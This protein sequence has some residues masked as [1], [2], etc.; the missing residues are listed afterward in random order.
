M[1]QL[2]EKMALHLPEQAGNDLRKV[3]TEY[4]RALET[5]SVIYEDEEGVKHQVPLPETLFSGDNLTQVI[6][7]WF[8]SLIT[9][10]AT[11]HATGKDAES[12]LKGDDAVG[13]FDN[14][15]DALAYLRSKRKIGATIGEDKTIVSTSRCELERAETTKLGMVGAL[16]RRIGSAVIAEPQGD[17]DLTLEDMGKTGIN[18]YYD[19]VRRGARLGV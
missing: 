11:R 16:L 12:I 17:E 2:A 3:L 7:T 6:N 5:K 14:M 18:T 15:S 8:N 13:I 1:T 19:L 9:V 10:L 4:V